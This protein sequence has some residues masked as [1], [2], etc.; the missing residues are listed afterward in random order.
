M[1]KKY[2]KFLSIKELKTPLLILCNIKF[3]FATLL[4][5]DSK[6][7]NASP[8]VF[9]Y[10]KEFKMKKKRAIVVLLYKANFCK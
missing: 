10:N 8:F 2:N 6:E 4:W 1:H 5:L 7:K 9:V 3:H